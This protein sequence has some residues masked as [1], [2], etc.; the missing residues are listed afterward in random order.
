MRLLLLSDATMNANAGGLS[1]TL[2]NIFL[3]VS[4]KD[5]LCITPK[6]SFVSSPPSEPFVNCYLT[7]RFE[8]ISI[9]NNRIA[10]YVSPF[11]NWFNFS[12]N[13]KMRSFDKIRKQI[14]DFNADVVVSCSNGNIG[15]LM[16]FKLLKGVAVREVFP[17]FMDDWMYQSDQKWSGGS[18]HVF[19]KRLLSENPSWLMISDE[20]ASI[21]S[22]RY[23]VTAERVLQIHNPVNLSNAPE[24]EP[25]KRH[26]NHYTIAYAGSLWPMHYDSFSLV[27][28]AISELKSTHSITLIIYTAE[29]FWKWHKNELEN[30]DVVYGGSI[31]YNQI[32]QKL[33]KAD[34]LLLCS[35]F[36]KEWYTHSKGSIQT[37]ITDYLMSKR[38]IIS[39]GPDYSAN[40][41][42]LKKYHCGVCMESYS[43]EDIKTVLLSTL[44]DLAG[45]QYNVENG[46]Q[47]LEQ[48]FSYAN[49]HKMVSEFIFQI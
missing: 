13:N 49:V 32:H 7:Y 23:N 4:P 45:L 14:K 26:K 35:S 46:W 5:L 20:L 1:Q 3:F 17:Y 43:L 18:T 33:A 37:K 24:V 29:S 30:F 22:E 10:K 42:F 19:V 38:L 27:A 9:P 11:I 12:Y 2:Y 15:L 25:L 16:H 40:H 31:P 34:A 48:K 44:K 41:N 28:E 8:I 21:L 36:R 39:C 6:K 47:L